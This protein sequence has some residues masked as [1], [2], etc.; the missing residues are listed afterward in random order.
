[1]LKDAVTFTLKKTDPRT[2]A[3]RGTLH[4]PHGDVET[5]VFMPVGT[6]ATVKAIKPDDVAR[7]GDEGC[8]L[9]LSNTYHLYLRPGHE[10]VKKA[11]GLHRFMNW[12]GAILTDSGGFQVFSLG[13]LRKISEEGVKFQSYIDGS[14]HFFTPEKSI[15]VQEALGADIIMA[16]DECV[17]LPAEYRYVKESVERTTR[18]LKRCKAAHRTVETQSLFGIMQGGTYDDLRR[19]SAEQIVELDLPGYAVGGLSV[20]ESKEDMYRVLDNCVDLLPA[21]KPRYLMGVGTPDCLF[22]G[23]ERGIDMFDCVIPTR[24]ARN[25][26][27]F[28]SR[29]PLS[30]KRSEFFD[31]FTPLDPDCD[32]T[33]CRNYSRAYLRHLFKSNEILAAMLL[34]EHNLHFLVR[35]METIRKAIEEDR[36]PELKKEFFDAYYHSG[37]TA[38][39]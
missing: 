31:D 32:C 24:N 3:R 30:I 1:M 4:T 19:L 35:T 33:V 34:T 10:L 15:E 37:T 22:E 16:F 39:V 28:T 36:F 17:Q 5:P 26:S 23:V 11:G 25:G 18:W 29:G 14:T 27:V 2:K 38:R 21:G 6:Q 13:P 9:I 12:N 7:L 20:G 8:G